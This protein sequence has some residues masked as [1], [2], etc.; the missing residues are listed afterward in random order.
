[1]QTYKIGKE[2]SIVPLMSDEYQN[3]LNSEDDFAELRAGFEIR[4]SSGGF[5]EREDAVDNRL[6][7]A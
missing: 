4:V 7:F 6:E 1:V 5:A 3:R 2:L